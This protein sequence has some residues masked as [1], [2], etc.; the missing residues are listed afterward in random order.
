MI[1]ELAKKTKKTNTI[2]FFILF[3]DNQTHIGLFVFKDNYFTE[4][5]PS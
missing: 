1:E 2:Q 3:N 5:Y 4:H